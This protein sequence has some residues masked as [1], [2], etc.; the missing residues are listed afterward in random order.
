MHLAIERDYLVS[1]PKDQFASLSQTDFVM[2][3]VE[4]TCIEVFFE[5]T[6]LK[7]HRRLRHVENFCGFGKTQYTSHGMKHLQTSI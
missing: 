4:K 5:L 1:V 7:S 2:R 6:H 3:S